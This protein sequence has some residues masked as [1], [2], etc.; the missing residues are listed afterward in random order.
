MLCV[1]C[2]NNEATLHLTTVI[3]GRGEESIHL[4]K[5]CGVETT[6][7]PT[8]EPGTQEVLPVIGRKCEFCG[9]DAFCGKRVEGRGRI[10]W[11]F[12]CEAEYRRTFAQLFVCEHPELMEPAK[13][14]SALL[15]LVSDPQQLQA[16]LAEAGERAVQVMK[17]R[18][19]GKN[20]DVTG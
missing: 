6:R 18:R 3:Y 7:L 4:C 2:Q 9:E 16:W 13:M 10:Y 19:Q 11:C 14:R 5:D 20:R 8:V 17:E 12:D 1:K 15:P